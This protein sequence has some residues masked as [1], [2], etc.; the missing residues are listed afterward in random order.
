MADRAKQALVKLT[1]E[2]EWEAKFAPNNQG[3]VEK[4][5]YGKRIIS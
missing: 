4:L 3:I 2:P 5:S 1:L